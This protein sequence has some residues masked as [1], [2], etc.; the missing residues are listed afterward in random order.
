MS[1][2]EMSSE[3]QGRCPVDRAAFSQQKT[4]RTVE[5]GDSRTVERGTDGVWHVRS[6]AQA[7][8]VLRSPDT[9]QAG[10]NAELLEKMPG[11][12]RSPILYQEGKEH[13]EQRKQTARFFSPR[14]VGENY[15]DLMEEF[16]GELIEDLRRKR[17]VEL[18]ELSFKLAVKVAGKVVGLTD[19]RL[20]GMDRRLEAFFANDITELGWS[21]RELLGFARSQTRVAAFFYLDVKPAI[22]AR[23]KE[24]KEDVISH[25]ISKGYGDGEILTECL[26][27]AAAGMVTTREFISI[28]AW[29]MLEQPTVRERYLA[30]NE[31]ERHALLQEILRLEPV[32]GHLYRRATTD[33]RLDDGEGSITIPAGSLINLHTYAANADTSVVGECP[34]MLEPGRELQAEKVGPA[35]MS[36]GDGSHRCPGAFVAIQESDVFLRR[37]LELE[38]LRIERKPSVSWSDLVAGYEL[39]GFTVALG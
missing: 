21:P 27:Y 12:M 36:F 14:A 38:E 16:A 11:G 39:R 24:P 30:G 34:L 33:L 35:V 6:H 37:L 5:P 32:V 10:F 3:D 26:T 7:R 1:E 18:D 15:R 2:V 22:E 9:K 25:L 31:E 29:H 13:N 4:T 20:P 19:S 23:K 17:R 8:A 28:A